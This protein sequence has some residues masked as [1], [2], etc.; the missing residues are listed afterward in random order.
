MNK[1]IGVALIVGGGVIGYFGYQHSQSIESKVVKVF[2]GGPTKKS[3][4]MMAGGAAAVGAGL[5]LLVKK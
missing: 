5:F 3:V 2:D 1:A 4:W